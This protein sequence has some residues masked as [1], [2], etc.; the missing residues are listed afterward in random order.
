ML[1]QYEKEGWVS[2]GWGLTRKY[3]KWAQKGRHEVGKQSG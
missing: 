1:G 2:M 3:L